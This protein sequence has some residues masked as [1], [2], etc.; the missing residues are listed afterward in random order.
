M[1]TLKSLERKPEDDPQ[2]EKPE[3]RY[4]LRERKAE[5][6]TDYV[7]YSAFQTEQEPGAYSE[8]LYGHD[9]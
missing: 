2:P 6:F 9:K 7:M 1:T 3:R 5:V 8:A 4:P